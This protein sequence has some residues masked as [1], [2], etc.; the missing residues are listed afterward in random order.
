MIHTEYHT[1]WVKA[2]SIPF[3]NQ[4]KTRMP[5]LIIPIQH[6]IA[7]SG[8]GNQAREKNKAYSNRKR[9]S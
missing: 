3:E 9:G 7:S 2:G 5:S 6:N 4:H 8:Q 1:E